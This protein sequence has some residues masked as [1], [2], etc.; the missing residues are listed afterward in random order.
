MIV[1]LV[2]CVCCNLHRVKSY[3][4]DVVVLTIGKY[5]QNLFKDNGMAAVCKPFTY[6]EKDPALA[7]NWRGKQRADNSV[8]LDNAITVS[9]QCATLVYQKVMI[10]SVLT[11]VN[12]V[13]VPK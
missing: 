6:P 7:N 11:L 4:F 8:S 13:E 12:Y 9:A 5:F 3:G 10:N 1:S 2:Q